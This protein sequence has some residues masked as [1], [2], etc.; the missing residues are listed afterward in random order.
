MKRPDD[1]FKYRKCFNCQRT[2]F[3]CFIY[4]NGLCVL[5]QLIKDNRIKKRKQEK[6]ND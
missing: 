1:T 6:D 5:C 4:V 3:E 2:E